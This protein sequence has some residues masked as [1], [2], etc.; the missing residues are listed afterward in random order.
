MLGSTVFDLK[1]IIQPNLLN[2]ESRN[3]NINVSGKVVLL[4]AKDMH[5]ASAC[6]SSHHKGV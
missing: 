2:V 6:T 5:I 1:H 3:V 4:A